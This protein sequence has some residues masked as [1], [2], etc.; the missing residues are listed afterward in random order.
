MI[1]F[2]HELDVTQI[3][4]RSAHIEKLEDA[5]Q[6]A[7]EIIPGRL[8]VAG[9]NPKALMIWP[10]TRL[11]AG[12]Y[13]VVVGMGAALGFTDIAG[14]TLAVGTPADP[15]ESVISTFDV[16]AAADAAGALQ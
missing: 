3:D 7:V 15:G 6:S 12:R 16:A 4:A 8:S 11:G 9:A 2:N 14:R 1:A 13:R 5:S 10:D